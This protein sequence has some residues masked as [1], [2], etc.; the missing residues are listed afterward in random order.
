MRGVPGAIS[1]LA[2]SGSVCVPQSLLNWVSLQGSPCIPVRHYATCNHHAVNS[3]VPII[4]TWRR[5]SAGTARPS[6]WRSP[7]PRV[8]PATRRARVPIPWGV[9]SEGVVSENRL[10][11]LHDS[12]ETIACMIRC[13]T[14]NQLP[15]LPYVMCGH[16]APILALDTYG[17]STTP[18][19]DYRDPGGS[20]A[21]KE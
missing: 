4:C 7:A 8:R 1:P 2:A 5:G 18:M 3:R 21:L 15:A 9:D 16:G 19:E 6:R 13:V 20:P 11:L 12:R 10:P 14:C 17:Q